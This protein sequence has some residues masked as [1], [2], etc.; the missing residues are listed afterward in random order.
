MA[1]WLL[2]G[3]YFLDVL[4]RAAWIWFFDD[5][6]V[7]IWAS[8]FSTK[9]RPQKMYSEKHHFWLGGG[10]GGGADSCACNSELFFTKKG[11]NLY[12]WPP[13]V[14]K[15]GKVLS[16]STNS[17]RNVCVCFCFLQLWIVGFLLWV[18][19]SQLRERSSPST[20]RSGLHVLP[21]TF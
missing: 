4:A 15:V 6:A 11:N 8:N 21:G 17:K 18:T 9:L 19:M 7:W 16:V 2:S 14:R 10:G 1:T 13:S 5:L 12:S 20:T 3:D